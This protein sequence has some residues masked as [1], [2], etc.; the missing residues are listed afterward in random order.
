MAVELFTTLTPIVPGR[1]GDLRR[2]LAALPTGENSPLQAVP[3]THTAR[4]VV[5]EY[6]GMGDPA[7]RRR[8]RPALL[9]FS[10]AVDGPVEPWL[11]G[12][13]TGLGPTANTVWSHCSRWPETAERTAVATWLLE[14][15]LDH[16]LPFLANSKATVKEICHS[17]ELRDQLATFAVRAQHERLSPTDL[18]KEFQREF[19]RAEVR[20][21]S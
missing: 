21:L 18:R 9:L 6:L 10:A 13:L 5:L 2:T 7:R 1:E 11:A 19:P 14:H 20:E 15:R 8:L 17:L 4:W 3:R 12:L 16:T